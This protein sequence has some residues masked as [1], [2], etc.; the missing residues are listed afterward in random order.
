MHTDQESSEQLPAKVARLQKSVRKQ[1]EQLVQK[2]AEISK[3]NNKVQ[4]LTLQLAEAR[5]KYKNMSQ[6]YNYL[7]TKGESIKQ[8]HLQTKMDLLILQSESL[9]FNRLSGA[10]EQ[11]NKLLCQEITIITN[12]LKAK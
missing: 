3:L 1:K 7:E 5:K 9:E 4:K 8:E 6:K 11:C 10:L 2:D 12:F